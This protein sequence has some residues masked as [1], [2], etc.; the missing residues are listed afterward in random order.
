MDAKVY[1]PAVEKT[2]A[3][4]LAQ[5]DALRAEALH[6]RLRALLRRLPSLDVR[7]LALVS[8]ALDDLDALDRI[9]GAR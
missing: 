4:V 5:L 9:G 1:A 3:S 8:A 7:E 2:R 6:G